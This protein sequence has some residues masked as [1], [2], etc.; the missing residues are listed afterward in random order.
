MDI[1]IPIRFISWKWSILSQASKREAEY[2]G[3]NGCEEKGPVP[4][5]LVGASECNLL[6][7]TRINVAAVEMRRGGWIPGTSQRFHL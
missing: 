4:G 7:G 2:I 3:W 1:G 5:V 6:R